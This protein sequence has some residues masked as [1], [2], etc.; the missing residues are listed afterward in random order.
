MITKGLCRAGN[1]EGARRHLNDMY[2]TG[3]ASNLVTLNCLVD[4]LCR[5]GQIDQA[6][7]CLNQWKQGILL[8]T[9]PWCTIFARQG[10]SVVR[11]SYCFCV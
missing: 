10:D 5:A 7:N 3:F 1:I 2:M 6:M 9:P 11:L 4:R 8:C